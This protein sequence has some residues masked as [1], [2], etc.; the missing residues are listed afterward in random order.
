MTAFATRKGLT[1]FYEPEPLDE[2]IGKDVQ[3]DDKGRLRDMETG[4]ILP[5][6]RANNY[7]ASQRR[8][9]E[10]NEVG[11]LADKLTHI[12]DKYL[13]MQAEETRIY[14][15]RFPNHVGK[16]PPSQAHP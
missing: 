4:G 1:L 2:W 10:R 7:K 5:Q 11:R 13:P 16:L 15:G 14:V 8:H 12:V 9:R 3:E 6:A